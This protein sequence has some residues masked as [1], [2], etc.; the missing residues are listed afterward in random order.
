MSVIFLGSM[1]RRY[2]YPILEKTMFKTTQE[3]TVDEA[4]EEMNK[5]V[6]SYI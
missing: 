6:L 2:C 4:A 1:E 5:V 3:S